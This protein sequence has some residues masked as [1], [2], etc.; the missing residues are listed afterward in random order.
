MAN[1]EILD[2]DCRSLDPRRLPGFWLD[3]PTVSTSYDEYA[4]EV[5]G[6]VVGKPPAVGI[7]LVHDDVL[8]RQ[9]AVRVS[10]PDVLAQHPELLGSEKCG[11]WTA[12]GT[13]GL[14]PNFELRL[15]VVH[16]DQTRETLGVIKGRQRS[17]DSGFV[18]KIQPVMI[19]SL[20]RTGTTWLMRLLAEHPRIVAQ[21]IYPY[22]TRASGYWMH[23][24]KVLTEPSDVY[25]SSNVETFPENLSCV[26]HHPHYYTRPTSESLLTCQ[27]QIDRWM[28]RVYIERVAALC[29]ESIDEFYSNVARFQQELPPLYFVEKY[30]QAGHLPWMIWSLYPKAREIFLVR[31]FRDMFCSMIAFDRKRGSQAFGRKQQDTEEEFI[32]T[33]YRNASRLLADWKARS[34]RS[35]L[36]RYEDL[37]LRPRGT[38]GQLLEYLCLEAN[39]AIVDQMIRASE[40]ALELQRHQTVFPS[41]SSIGRWRYDLDGTLRTTCEVAFADLLQQLGYV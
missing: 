35:H 11:F 10:R 19:S 30:P 15:D 12:T 37:V 1:V 26:G 8:V 17:I 41:T 13:L 3:H 27:G 9:A 24:L 16:E 36:L 34:A 32:R 31:D 23:V 33:L 38:L 29:Q 28:G 2:F 4:I 25:R 22:E 39:D 5:E 18:P 7:E 21:R 40:D 6:W 20:G 14:A